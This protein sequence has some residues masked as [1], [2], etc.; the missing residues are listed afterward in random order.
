MRLRALLACAVAVAAAAPAS[1][2][3]QAAAEP[4]YQRYV[5]L[6][7]SYA[8]G[9]QIP[10]PVPGSVPG[11]GRSTANYP[12][13]LAAW[14]R[15]PTFVDV[16]CS[17]ATTAH[18]TGPQAVPGGVNPA[19]FTALT[20]DTDLVTLT[21]GGNDMGF[22]RIL[23]TCAR[24]GRA[25]PGGDR[26][27]AYF[28]RSG[29]DVPAADVA[30]AGRRITALLRR[31][32]E[33]APRARVVVVGYARIL[34]EGP[35]CWPLMPFAAGDTAYFDSVE[36]RLDDSLAAAAA[37]TGS[38]HVDPYRYGTGHDACAAP[39]RR[40]VEPLLPASPA[41]AVHPNARGMAAVA[42]LAWLAARR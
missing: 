17:G 5:A 24:E 23:E 35:G 3:P 38:D 15:V 1:A 22:G 18:L 30:A 12:A 39:E 41:A 4:G 16:T 34:P 2:A 32:H 7:D 37:A 28:T 6:G 9:P 14:L 10:G 8:A 19:Q 11:C 33:L 13:L 40:W 20:P 25:D 26:C 42:A 29:T 31:V 21:I 27:R 36:R